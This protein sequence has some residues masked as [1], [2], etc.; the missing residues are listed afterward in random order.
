MTLKQKAT[1]HTRAVKQH[2]VETAASQATHLVFRFRARFRGHLL[3]AGTGGGTGGRG[4]RRRGPVR[5]AITIAVA[6]AAGIGRVPVV[7]PHG[8][9]EPG[10]TL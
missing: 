9:C 8:H 2:I 4:R 5:S 10:R 3:A 6:V 1:I 7:D